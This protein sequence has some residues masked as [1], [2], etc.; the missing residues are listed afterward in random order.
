MASFQSKI[1][2][3]VRLRKQISMIPFG[4]IV[5]LLTSS[6]STSAPTIPGGILAWIICYR[7]R[8]NAIGGWLLFFYWQL[9]SSLLMTAVFF[10]INIQSYVPEN[11]D[12]TEKFAL[13]LLSVVPE[14]ILYLA[15]IAV[16][17][18]LLSV[19]TWDVLKLLRW[20]T[21]GH[22]LAGVLGLVIGA[23]YFPDPDTTGM[24]LVL[25]VIPQ[26]LWL[27]YLFRSERVRHV[28]KSHDW[29]LAVN[30]MHPINPKITT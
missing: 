18:I 8:R 9:Y 19:R 3:K 20:L 1:P 2:I 15:Q 27:I 7:A 6:T 21:A 11:F 4:S 13:F 10:S 25:D 30:N 24:T 17:T 16:G 28:F 14:F 5:L 22:V 29:E 12:S 26:S 23:R